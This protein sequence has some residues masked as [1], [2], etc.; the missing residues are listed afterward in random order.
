MWHR[1][2]NRMSGA[3]L[4]GVFAALLVAGAPHADAGGTRLG[5][6]VAGAYSFSDE[7]G[8]FR[9]TA[10]S[11]AGTAADPITVTEELDSANPVTL[12]IRAIRP[13]Q[14]PG[15]PGDYATGFVPL[16]IVAFNNSDH[17]WTEFEFELQS[18][19]GRPSDFGDGLSFDQALRQTDMIKS[20]SFAEFQRQFEPSDRLLFLKGKVDPRQTVSFSFLVTDFSP[21]ERFYLVQEPRIPLS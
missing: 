16:R 2:S 3:R 4:A 7:L 13:V 12:T 17:A 19:L 11:G 9:I 15:T 20:D 6:F 18:I 14:P 21:A 8:G 10:V 5:V 1:P